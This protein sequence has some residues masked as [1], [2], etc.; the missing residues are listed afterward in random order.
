MKK[1]QFK[2]IGYDAALSEFI[3]NKTKALLICYDDQET[4]EMIIQKLEAD[5]PLRLAFI[6]P[7]TKNLISK[8]RRYMIAHR[9]YHLNNGSY[10]YANGQPMHASGMIEH[11][12]YGSVFIFDN[13]EGMTHD[14]MEK[15]PSMLR[16][17]GMPVFDPLEEKKFIFLLDKAKFKE[18]QTDETYSGGVDSMT[19][20]YLNPVK[21]DLG[22]STDP[23]ISIFDEVTSN[24]QP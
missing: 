24:T 23:F 19:F 10:T 20:G 1:L 15:L 13:F 7:E 12:L 5:L 14:F 8:D 2:W 4:K 21:V 17:Y 9:A 6:S 3:T 22:A 11:F 18:Y 16:H